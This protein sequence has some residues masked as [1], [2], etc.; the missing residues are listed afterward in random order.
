M[1]IIR[2]RDRFAAFGRRMWR[3]QGLVEMLILAAILVAVCCM[4]GCAVTK[5]T[6][7]QHRHTTETW[8][9]DLSIP[10][11]KPASDG[12]WSVEAQ[13]VPFTITRTINESESAESDSK[14][15][16]DPAA[17]A[18]IGGAL[19]GSL[20]QAFPALGLLGQTFMGPPEPKDGGG[21]MGLLEGGGAGAAIAAAGAE[22]LRRA[23]KASRAREDE[24][25]EQAQQ[26]K[27]DHARSEARAQAL[28]EA[29]A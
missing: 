16:V 7:T 13:P 17:I 26:A 18:Q 11:P 23:A 29:K 15:G 3:I 22:A 24:A 2:W 28:A 20:K 5:T 10:L 27:I 4:G 25:W 9:G 19:A 6:S 8:S 12:R 1:T 14:T 21:L